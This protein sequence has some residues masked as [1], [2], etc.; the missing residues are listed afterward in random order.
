MTLLSDGCLA[1][2]SELERD[3]LKIKAIKEGTNRHG[4]SGPPS[5]CAVLETHKYTFELTLVSFSGSFDSLFPGVSL[6][7]GETDTV[8]AISPAFVEV[9]AAAIE[10]CWE[11]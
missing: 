9:V 7:L 10:S 8:V 1:T 5:L 2:V 4:R 3:L 11:T 6:F